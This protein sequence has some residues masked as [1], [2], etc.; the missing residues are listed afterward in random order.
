M[1]VAIS[2]TLQRARLD[3][4]FMNA[5]PRRRKLWQP[6]AFTSNLEAFEFPAQV[7][8]PGHSTGTVPF[9]EIRRLVRSR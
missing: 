8:T 6:Q 3:Q 1:S 7:V 5:R 9:F 4:E 2:L